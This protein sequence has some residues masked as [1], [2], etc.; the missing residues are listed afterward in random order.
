MSTPCCIALFNTEQM[1]LFFILYSSHHTTKKTFFQTTSGQVEESIFAS[2]ASECLN[3]WPGPD[4]HNAEVKLT[5]Q[6][7][8]ENDWM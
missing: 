6:G 2:A 1:G 3:Q 7:V 5:E 4:W 8:E